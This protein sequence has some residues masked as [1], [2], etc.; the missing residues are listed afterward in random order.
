MFCYARDAKGPLGKRNINLARKLFVHVGPMKTGTTAIQEILA[1]HDNSIV[2][3]PKIGLSKNAHH[4]LVHNYRGKDHQV[5]HCATLPRGQLLDAFSA[6]TRESARNVV[7][8][9]EWLGTHA[10]AACI[11]QFMHALANRVAGGRPEVEI[12]VACREHFD[13]AASVYGQ[14]LKTGEQSAPDDFIKSNADILCHAPLITSLRRTGFKVVPLSYHPSRDWVMRFFTYLGFAPEQ[15]PRPSTANQS[16]APWVLIARMAI[17]NVLTAGD[18][19]TASL[20]RQIVNRLRK[21]D[22]SCLPAQFLFSRSVAEELKERFD[23]DRAYLMRKFGIELPVPKIATMENKFF[24][25]HES[26]KKVES[27]VKLA[28]EHA[29]E[30]LKIVSPYVRA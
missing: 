3:Y 21:P 16:F 11:P 28:G 8:S 26:F 14:K 10:T 7:V 20:K 19:E 13:R 2:L 1:N 30:I 18:E 24:M 15:I 5:R 6:A 29:K 12:L 17:N 23:G 27:A 4:H 25:D 22:E 9:S